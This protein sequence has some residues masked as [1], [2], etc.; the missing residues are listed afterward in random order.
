MCFLIFSKANITSKI[1]THSSSGIVFVS[2]FTAEIAFST[3]DEMEVMERNHD[4]AVPLKVLF[5]CYIT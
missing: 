3:F 1:T 4:N 2:T 5:M